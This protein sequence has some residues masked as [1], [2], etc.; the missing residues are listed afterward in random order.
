M[1]KLAVLAAGLLLSVSA[2]AKENIVMWH[3][4]RG[5]LEEKIS[6]MVEDYNNSQDQ[7]HVE[8]IYQGTYEETIAKF[9]AVSGTKEAPEIVQMNDVSTAFM[10]RS[11]AITPMQDLIEKDETFDENKLEPAL[12][13]YYRIGGKLYSMPFNSSTSVLLYNKDAFR[14]AGLDPERPP[15]SYKEVAEYAAKLTKKDEAG[16]V[17]RYGF[18][19]IIY[20]WFIEQFLANENT[21]YVNNE[22]GRTGE[23]PTEVA[24]GE[25]LPM[26]LSWLG[27]MCKDGV[28]NTYGRDFSAT[29]SAFASG[30]IA[31]YMD[32]SAGI[33]GVIRNAKFDSGAAYIPNESGEF[34][35]SVI[36]GGSLWISNSISEAK[37]N[38]AWDFVKYTVSKDVQ[39]DWAKSS[40][41]FPVNKD[42]YDVPV[43]QE[44]M[45]SYPQFTVVV[46]ELKDSK[47]S[48]T[49]Q[50]AILGVF[51][52]V[53]DKIVQ[54]MEDV[55]EGKDAIKASD[56]AV[57]ASNRIISRFNRVNN[58]K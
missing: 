22:N 15:R 31:M 17:D 51:P 34:Y 23:L 28:A 11:G 16:V 37:Q 26:I 44:F 53:R 45:A 32:S 39:A 2:L 38:A 41:Y 40:G 35:G 19:M 56:A 57:K 18:S 9:K 24:Y 33:S 25:K 58:K 12:L 47:L 1:K 5:A 4:M 55:C 42:S 54:A 10:Y 20:G 48:Y 30:K 13:N 8:A 3:S 49:T 50:G 36:G 52:D 21:L 27:Q 46:N 7:V 43:L 6:Q 14:E 29:R